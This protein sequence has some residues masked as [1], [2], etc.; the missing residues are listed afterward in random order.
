MLRMDSKVASWQIEKEC[1]AREPTQE[2]YLALVYR[3]ESYFKGFTVEYIEWNKNTEA[4]DLAKATTH[5]TPMSTDVFFQVIKYTSV[6]TVLRAEA[7]KC[8][9]RRRL[10]ST[11]NGL[12]PSLLWAKQQKHSPQPNPHSH[13]IDHSSL[14]EVRR[15]ENLT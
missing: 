8:Y 12:P 13:E 15:S 2:K 14:L 11:D 10:E 4:K 3:M 1:I 5:N 9:W 6:K 7:Y